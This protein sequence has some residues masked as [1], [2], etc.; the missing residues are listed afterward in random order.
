M[1]I[2]E[3]IKIC[4]IQNNLTQKQLGEK[5]FVS[6]KTISKWESNRSVPDVD[7]IKKLAEVLNIEYDVLIDG[8]EARSNK[9]SLNK[10]ILGFVSEQKREIIYGSVL[11]VLFV[12]TN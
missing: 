12:T 10:Q 8:N 4:R 1:S 11:F 2:A 9:K 5:M 7:T 6:D 3:N